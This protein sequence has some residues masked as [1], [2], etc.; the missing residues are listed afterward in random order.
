[1]DPQLLSIKKK[2]MGMKLAMM[3]QECGYSLEGLANAT[4]MDPAL[5]SEVEQGTVNPS[6]PQLEN[7]AFAFGRSIDE[8]ASE[9]PAETLRKNWDS[10]ELIKR[11]KLHD[12]I[13]GLKLKKSRLNQ[14]I[15]IESMAQVCGLTPAEVEAFESGKD[16]IPFLTL[17]TLCHELGFP[18]S[19]LISVQVNTPVQP[20]SNE[21][22]P[23]Q[24]PATPLTALD[25]PDYLVDFVS[26]PVNLPFVELA[27]KMSQM[28]ARKLRSIAESILEITL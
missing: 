21:T 28:E 20:T 18:Y 6:L 1:M 23:E 12:R 25:L 27:H 9:K 16:S 22:L 2:K 10:S 8:L 15:A 3:R 13:I 17:V 5:L 11:E 4:G 26:K 19:E 24:T 7:L 14:Q